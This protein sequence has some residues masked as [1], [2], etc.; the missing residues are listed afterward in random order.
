MFSQADSLI[1]RTKRRKVWSECEVWWPEPR[2]KMAELSYLSGT[3]S[4]SFA[5]ALSLLQALISCGSISYH[6]CWFECSPRSSS[7]HRITPLLHSPVDSTETWQVVNF[8]VWMQALSRLY[9]SFVTAPISRNVDRWPPHIT[10]STNMYS[11]QNFACLWQYFARLRRCSDKMHTN[12]QNR[13]STRSFHSKTSQRLPP[14]FEMLCIIQNSMN[15]VSSS[16][17]SVT[18][19]TA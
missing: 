13:W 7:S 6:P 16:S 10:V 11:Q 9:P 19:G 8:L 1:T 2:S 18:L 4:C 5:H 15:L 17:V 12:P 3:S 14:C